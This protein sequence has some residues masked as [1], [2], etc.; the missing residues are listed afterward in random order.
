MKANLTSGARPRPGLIFC[1]LRSVTRLTSSN[2]N[3]EL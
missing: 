1:G 3:V 2:L